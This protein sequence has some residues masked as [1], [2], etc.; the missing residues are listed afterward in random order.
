LLLHVL[1]DDAIESVLV[2]TRTKYGAD[3]VAR[4]LNKKGSK[5]AAIHGDKSQNNRQKAL[6]AFK[7]GKLRVL[8]ATDIAARG[9]DIDSLKYVINFEISNMPETYVHRIGRSGRAGKDGVAISFCDH[10]ERAY[11]KDIHKLTGKKLKEISD[12]PFPQSEIDP[13]LEDHQNG[14]PNKGN[15]KKNRDQFK[16]SKKIAKRK[17]PKSKF[18]EKRALEAEEN[19][20]LDL[21]TS[22][23]DNSDKVKKNQHKEEKSKSKP[24]KGKKPFKKKKKGMPDGLKKKMMWPL[25]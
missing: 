11:V 17:P 8:V 1:K 20:N 7:D 4:M 23:N 22:T 18:S 5:A 25:G 10:T 14:K 13:A 3:K 21:V 24:P 19:K 2:F 16:S 9:I 6:K 15:G 12:H